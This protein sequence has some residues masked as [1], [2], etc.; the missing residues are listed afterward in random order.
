VKKF[1]HLLGALAISA[2][3][4]RSVAAHANYP[5]IVRGE[6]LVRGGYAHC[7][8]SGNVLGKHDLFVHLGGWYWASLGTFADPAG[9][10]RPVWQLHERTDRHCY[11]DARATG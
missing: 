6:Y 2:S 7:E 10:R 1:T 4:V 3:F 5:Q 9:T 8:T 11:S